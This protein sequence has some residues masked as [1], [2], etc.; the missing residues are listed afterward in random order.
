[1]GKLKIGYRGLDTDGDEFTVVAKAGKGYRD[2]QYHTGI[3]ACGI[4]TQHMG[5]DYLLGGGP[6]ANDNA[7]ISPEISVK[8][9]SADAAGNNWVPKVGDRVKMNAGHPYFLNSDEHGEATEGVIKAT[10]GD[11]HNY[12]A[13]YLVISDDHEQELAYHFHELS[14]LTTPTTWAPVVGKFGKTRDGRKVGPMVRADDGIWPWQLRAGEPGT[15]PHGMLEA[16]TE[17]GRLHTGDDNEDD[18]VAEWVEPAAEPVA[19]AP[20]TATPTQPERKF[21]VGDVVN[22][23]EGKSQ[24]IW[25]GVTITKDTGYL[26]YATCPDSGDG[27]FKDEWIELAAPPAKFKV[28]DRVVYVGKHAD[29]TSPERIGWL[30]TV[31]SVSSDCA[32]VT[33]DN[34]EWGSQFFANIA[35]TSAPPIGSQ[36][37]ITA[38]GRLSAINENGHYQVTF[39]GLPSGKNS[40]AL[41]AAHVAAAK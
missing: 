23:I 4:V 30:G 9:Y 36:V 6:V 21:K 17:T 25:Q 14:P 33:Y 7:S 18:L 5:N 38:T 13:K 22:Y 26:Y 20:A 28:G 3:A 8:A 39:P 24:N 10:D 27:A 40:F 34:G 35:L 31:K 1:M 32:E 29:I 12:R 2:V 11:E 37:T 15:S 16:W 19:V 41:P